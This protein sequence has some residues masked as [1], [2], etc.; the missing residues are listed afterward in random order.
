MVVT[1]IN[2]KKTIESSDNWVL[3]NGNDGKSTLPKIYKVVESMDRQ[4]VANLYYEYEI[5]KLL[6]SQFTLTPVE[7][8]LED[9]KHLLVFEN[10]E[11]TSLNKYIM[12]PLPIFIFLKI[13]IEITNGFIDMQHSSVIY[14]NIH[15]RN[16]LINEKT[17]EVK[18]INF[19]HAYKFHHE[20]SLNQEVKYIHTDRLSYYAPEETGR[21][22][23]TIDFRTDLYSLGVLFYEMLTGQLP[24]QNNEPQQL[25]YQIMT[26]EPK[27]I[28]KLNPAVPQV[29]SAI[30][31]KLLSKNKADR[32][33]SATG[34]K[35]DLV[36]CWN[37][38]INNK[39]IPPFNLGTHDKPSFITLNVEI[40]SQ[41]K[42]ANEVLHQYIKRDMN[43]N[44]SIFIKGHTGSGEKELLNKLKNEW[45]Q[46]NAVVLDTSIELAMQNVKLAPIILSIRNQLNTIYMEGVSY[47]E[48][49]QELFAK[50]NI[51]LYDELLKLIPELEWFFAKDVIQSNLL[52]EVNPVELNHY[53]NLAIKGILS[54]L[55]KS[56]GSLIM[57]ITN[58]DLM[59]TS[60]LDWIR[61]VNRELT[62]ICFVFTYKNTNEM[63]VELQNL[64]PEHQTFELV[65]LT[66][67]EVFSWVAESLKESS[68]PVRKMAR[69]LF[70]LTKGNPVYI[71][72]L[73]NQFMKLELL[74]YSLQS[75]S[76]KFDL[77]KMEDFNVSKNLSEFFT[78]RVD[79]LSEKQKMVLKVAACIGITFEQQLLERCLDL[80]RAEIAQVMLS[81]IQEGCI[82]P[83][84]NRLL[85]ASTF[86][87][88]S[89]FDSSELAFRFVHRDIQKVIYK[90]IDGE[91]LMHTHYNVAKLLEE[92]IEQPIADE[93]L[94]EIVQHY[95]KSLPLLTKAEKF[96]VAEWNIKIG[97]NTTASGLFQNA[98]H[99]LDV[100]IALLKNN[101][102]EEH[103]EL[104]LELWR[105]KGISE[106]M[107]NANDEAER[108]FNEALSHAKTKIEKLK[109]Y[110]E[111]ILFYTSISPALDV[112]D[113]YYIQNAITTAGDALKLYDIDLKEKVSTAAI[114]K[115]FSLLNI[116]LRKKRTQELLHLK[117]NEDES[118]YLIM[119]VLVN[120]MGS[121]LI[122]D[123][124]LHTWMIIRMMRLILKH[125][126]V[127]FSSIIYIMYAS[128]L[129]AGF[130]DTNGSYE[131][132]MLAIQ[133]MERE[134]KILYKTHVYMNY[135]ITIG[136][137]KKPYVNSVY[138]LK[139]A[140]DYCLNSELHD[141]F[142]SVTTTFLIQIRHV[143][144]MPI[145]DILQ[146]INHYKSFLNRTKNIASI[147]YVTEYV[148]WLQLLKTPTNAAVWDKPVTNKTDVSFWESHVVLRL[149]M[150]YLLYE[151]R[152]ASS[153]IDELRTSVKI[154]VETVSRPQLYFY[155]A[156]WMIKLLRNN[157]NVSV[158]TKQQYK[159]HIQKSIKQF[160]QYS[161]HAPENF[162]HLLYLLQAEYHSYVKKNE[163]AVLF[164]DRSIQ[165]A[166]VNGFICDQA[167]A[168]HC[169][170][171]YYRHQ[172]EMHRASEYMK[173]AVELM[174]EWGAQHVAVKWEN[175][176]ENFI[177]N[178][179]GTSK[180]EVLIPFDMN[181]VIEVNQILA[182]ET[183]MDD[184]I[185]QVLLLMMKHADA[186]ISYFFKK[187]ND[188]MHFIG[189]AELQNNSFTLAH[190]RGAETESIS[191]QS[192]M[193]YVLKS[194]QHVLIDNTSMLSPFHLGGEEKTI[195]CLPI[196]YQGNM[197]AILYLANTQMPY[198]FRKDKI[199]LLKMISSQIA[200]SI[201]HTKM[202]EHLGEQVRDRTEELQSVNSYLNEVNER[203]QQN[204]IE[205]KVLLQNVS[206]DLRS[207]IT[208]VL[209]YIEAILDGIV[210]DPKQQ[211]IHLI[212]SKE[213]LISLNYLIHDL[214][215]L[216]KLESGRTKLE[217]KSWPVQ[218]VFDLFDEKYRADIE[219]ANIEY[220][221]LF[222]AE[223]EAYIMLDLERT[224]QVLNNLISN[225]IK[226]TP[227]GKI[228]FSMEIVE[229]N[230]IFAVE[231]NG[232]GI[233][234]K[235]LPY[236]FDMHFRA[237]NNQMTNSYGIGLSICKQIVAYQ[238]GEILVESKE[239]IGSIFKVILKLES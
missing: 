19:E 190:D 216:S 13:A 151:E 218:R 51:H 199:E 176:Y 18:I 88:L 117:R 64:L 15:R 53:F 138:Y 178:Q 140:L 161:K 215:E 233:P 206:H 24:F 38:V 184:L 187:E 102:W 125:G 219:Q 78:R 50:E 150:S 137:W 195:L 107:N 180:K 208:S 201:E 229:S 47:V 179:I 175:Q 104:M 112:G 128:V 143:Q 83:L 98:G 39:K 154:E 110:N 41:I 127:E 181:T 162:E 120:T 237:T 152:V 26:S 108:Y 56:K 10:E 70:D 27:A 46:Q 8:V 12:Q 52:V 202:Y 86:N 69:L 4:L 210:S 134:N 95:N 32:Y 228:Q 197:T 170:A 149:Q 225:A 96:K 238:N 115:E 155:S 5:I 185:R 133:H 58:A 114:L 131:F 16:F 222:S 223:R 172:D 106:Y 191:L 130:K 111:K 109:L 194:E 33:Q 91:L 65:P 163:D 20:T 74:Y 157:K 71:Q 89:L 193:Q 147:E 62:G 34:L 42:L 23:E 224:W 124:K 25:I 31:D 204:E 230:V 123:K 177:P 226:Y 116:A 239:G 235:D 94:I 101:G 55:L 144:N 186:N 92:L 49:I 165:L 60:M 211:Q 168:S 213:R 142:A 212:R 173:Q 182:N 72:E 77:K 63:I 30:V 113:I 207:P 196:M 68:E 171:E 231:D 188:Q 214:F 81:L 11:M 141:L 221:S 7:I 118:I 200:I 3:I 48:Q 203:L 54:A 6:Q 1:F 164:Y 126:D 93:A 183:K 232:M 132:G 135:G 90:Q 100:A 40:P 217:L 37:L 119:T 105:I 156:L 148:D 59:D 174:Y 22:N 44:P 236:I 234:E 227:A 61:T 66:E 84:N 189:K 36:Y 45:T 167:I 166:K 87:H 9:M 17:Y 99:F 121:A 35:E 198:V 82:V 103:R 122:I 153:I 136:Y 192:I 209:G 85:L 139:L 145:D 158:K 2:R 129:K 67:G 146:E 14:R 28:Y 169:A 97:R 159:R 80:T 29:V 57:I 160:K 43:K 75:R 76:W 21:L 205:R 79:D 73:F 220:E